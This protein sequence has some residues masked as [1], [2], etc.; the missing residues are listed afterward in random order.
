MQLTLIKKNKL[1]VFI[2]PEKVS[3]SYWITDFENGKKLNLLSVE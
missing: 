3:G 2:L 1:S